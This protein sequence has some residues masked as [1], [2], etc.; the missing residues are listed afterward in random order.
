MSINCGLTHLI[1]ECP[2]ADTN[3]WTL[4]L[5]R[6]KPICNRRLRECCKLLPQWG[7]AVHRWDHAHCNSMP[8]A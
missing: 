6:D 8:C 4:W 5:D 1:S 2:T 3:S 7:H